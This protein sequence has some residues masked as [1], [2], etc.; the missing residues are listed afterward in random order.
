MPSSANI[1]SLFLAHVKV[2]PEAPVLRVPS[3]S[4]RGKLRY[5]SYSFSDLDSKVDATAHYLLDQGIRPGYRVLLMLKPSLEWLQLVFA[6][7]KIGAVPILLDPGLGLKAYLKSIRHSKVDVLVGIAKGLILSHACP[8]AFPELQQRIWISPVFQKTIQP[9][10]KKGTFA[11]Y[12][13]QPEDVAAIVFT[14]GST[15]AP[16]GVRYQHQHFKAQVESVRNTYHIEPRTIDLPLLAIFILF[17]PVLGC[18]SILPE[19]DASQPAQLK[20]ERIVQAILENGVQ[21]SF[22]SPALWVKIAEYCISK[23]LNLPTVKRILIAGTALSPGLLRKL[24]SIL[25]NGEVHTPYGATECLP[26]S[27]IDGETLLETE[28]SKAIFAGTCLGRPVE[29]VKIAI[30]AP[31]EGCIRHFKEASF[32]QTGAV[33]EIIVQGPMVTE[34]YDHLASATALAKIPDANGFWH[35]MGDLGYI[36]ADGLLWFC[37]RKVEAVKT[38]H[39]LLYTEPCER[40][41]RDDPRIHRVALIA[42]GQEGKAVALV[43]EPKK[44]HFPKKASQ[45]LAFRQDLLSLAKSHPT[46][47]AIEA[48]FFEPSLPV[49]VRHNAKIHRL[50]LRERY[51]A[52]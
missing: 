10:F 46:T 38:I 43:V 50:K 51:K 35:R 40:I 34:Q 37:G 11:L 6:L 39:G 36:D 25:P 13:S 30:I 41:F 15:G 47:Q 5:T 44:D 18:V 52:V 33:G 14:S 4:I 7:F 3:R 1:I 16:K 32:L 19:V 12:P 48:V 45:L 28:P 21:T 17:N 23:K 2:Q 22:G 24:R 27:T 9:Y 26:I 29:G 42:L 49:D 8:K 31:Q 20:P